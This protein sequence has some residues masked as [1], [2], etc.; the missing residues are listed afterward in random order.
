LGQKSVIS[1]LYFF[2]KQPI[3]KM[4]KLEKGQ[5]VV[6]NPLPFLIHSISDNKGCFY[7]FLGQKTAKNDQKM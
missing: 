2:E 4:Q 3:K 5:K 6:K 1:K 7:A